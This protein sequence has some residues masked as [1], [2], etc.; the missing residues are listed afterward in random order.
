MVVVGHA[1][2]D[3][4]NASKKQRMDKVYNIEQS[5]MAKDIICIDVNLQ[6]VD[7]VELGDIIVVAINEIVKVVIIH[8]ARTY[9]SL[10][11]IRCMRLYCHE[12]QVISSIIRQQE[13]S[14]C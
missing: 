11:G 5:E 7:K 10:D 14:V 2:V 8:D 9:K 4:I 3:V 6:Y 13:V 1:Q 12:T